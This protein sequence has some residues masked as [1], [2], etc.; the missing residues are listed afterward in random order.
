MWF[1]HT[2]GALVRRR[3]VK[4]GTADMPPHLRTF[5]DVVVQPAEAQPQCLLYRQQP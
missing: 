5:A 2:R 1:D 3:D 4:T